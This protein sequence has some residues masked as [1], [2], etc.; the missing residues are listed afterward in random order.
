MLNATVQS[1]PTTQ[2][3]AFPSGPLSMRR[4][5]VYLRDGNMPRSSKSVR[6][7]CAFSVVKSKRLRRLHVHYGMSTYDCSLLH[8]GKT[9]VLISRPILAVIYPVLW[10]SQR[11]QREQEMALWQAC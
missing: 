4:E 2:T 10:L 7:N 6:R 9:A 5:R 8:R 3:C 1:S 11:I